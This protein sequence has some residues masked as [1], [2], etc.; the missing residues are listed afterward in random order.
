MTG[1]PAAPTQLV[2]A[3]H[4]FVVASA[5]ALDAHDPSSF[6]TRQPLL[7]TLFALENAGG[8]PAP[9]QLFPLSRRF[10]A[11]RQRYDQDPTRFDQTDPHLGA[12]FAVED[13]EN[14]NPPAFLSAGVQGSPPAVQFNRSHPS[15][16][17]HSAF[18]PRRVAHGPS[19]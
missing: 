15:A 17:G 11:A 6:L 18:I 12:V 4:R 1:L 9:A 3:N 16:R 14:G 13:V 5:R 19:V 10:E 7:G 8:G 2:S